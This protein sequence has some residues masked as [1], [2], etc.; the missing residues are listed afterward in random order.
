MKLLA[1]TRD[2]YQ[3]FL[4][5]NGIVLPNLRAI[6]FIASKESVLLHQDNVRQHIS[7]NDV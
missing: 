7:L 3:N 5:E 2:V 4:V 1:G 6:F